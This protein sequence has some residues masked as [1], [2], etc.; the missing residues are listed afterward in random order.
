MSDEAENKDAP[1][2]HSSS[3]QS[4]SDEDPYESEDIQPYEFCSAGSFFDPCPQRTTQ[5]VF[6]YHSGRRVARLKS[7]R[8]LYGVSSASFFQLPRWPYECQVLKEKI[9]HIEWEPPV[10]EPMYRLTGLEEEPACADPLGSK[11]VYQVSEGWK[12][13]YFMCA[14]VGGSCSPL[15]PVSP[16]SCDDSDSVLV[17]ESRFESGNLQKAVQVGKH[18]YELT[19]RTD[20][21]TDRHTQWYYFRV[22]N[23]K[24]GILYRFTIINFMKPS[25]LYNH[26]MRPLM[27]SETEA[28]TRQIGWHRIGD[29]VKYYKNNLGQDGQSYYSL[30]WKFRFPH[31]RDVCYFAH[32]YPYT[33]SNLQD[34][35]AG[36]ASNPERSKYCKIR[37]LCHSLAGNIVYVLTITNPFPAAKERKKKAVILTARVHPGETNSSWVMKGFLDYILSSQNDARLLRDTFIFKVVPMLNPDGVIVGNYRCSLTGRD[38]N[39]NYKSRLK[40]SFPSIW[41]TRNMIKRVMEE[42]EILLYCDLHG[43]SRKQNVFMYGCKGSGVQNGGRRLSER[44]FPF[45]LSKNSPDK[46]SF[47][48]CKFKVQRNK[49]GTGRVVMWKMGIQ[50]SYTLEATFCGSTLGNRRGT[51][52][53][54]KDLESLG[55]HFCDALL[56][57]CDP[58]LTKY[59]VCLKELEDV[60]KQKINRQLSFKS[61]A[62]LDVLSDLDSSTGGSDSS[63]SNGPPAHLMELACKV[64]PRKKLLK[65][66]RERNSQRKQTEQRSFQEPQDNNESTK[67]KERTDTEDRPAHVATVEQSSLEK[68]KKLRKGSKLNKAT[69]SKKQR[70]P[71]IQGLDAQKVS[72]IYLVFNAKGEVISTKSHSYAN[73]RNVMEFTSSLKG[74]PWNKPLPLFKSLLSQRFPFSGILEPSCYCIMP[75]DVSDSPISNTS[76][77]GYESGDGVHK[78][79]KVPISSLY[80]EGKFSSSGSL[81]TGGSPLERDTASSVLAGSVVRHGLSPPSE[82]ISEPSA[83]LL[84]SDIEVLSNLYGSAVQRNYVHLRQKN[85]SSGPLDREDCAVGHRHKKETASMRRVKGEIFLPSVTNSTEAK[86]TGIDEENVLNPTTA[87]KIWHG[88]N[89]LSK[90]AAHSQPSNSSSST[91]VT[92]TRQGKGSSANGLLQKRKL[93]RSLYPHPQE[94]QSDGQYPTLHMNTWKDVLIGLQQSESGAPAGDTPLHF[95]NQ[96]VST[97]PKKNI[98]KHTN[99]FGNTSWKPGQRVNLTPL[100]KQSHNS[101]SSEF[102]LHHS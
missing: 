12:E 86:L 46:F 74:L 69:L 70:E 39:R 4:E 28:T 33:Y 62:F 21:Y 52:F 56:D 9:E 51:H 82:R 60:V 75:T 67:E 31:S 90:M 88:R 95:E 38:L 29:E 20:L 42:R 44:L 30:S 23:M 1:S 91:S 48:G 83:P 71:L 8:D 64:R 50:N 85:T 80:S 96:P 55:Q 24:A 7:P 18:E 66:K 72:V 45:M 11:L 19:L 97:P 40:D 15:E 76:C 79:V 26:G 57:Y 58:D 22:T 14:R 59:T 27:Y 17:F 43:H 73:E 49:E 54:T 89:T 25:S 3:S 93:R 37:V 10:P 47:S 63:N 13:S 102:C 81:W 6:E 2:E 41:F 35:L 92:P 84:P 87:T 98:S 16:C 68:P 77:H 78:S 100:P 65:S 61:E 94:V 34:Y 32:C 36:I 5:I 101:P 99:N 53:S